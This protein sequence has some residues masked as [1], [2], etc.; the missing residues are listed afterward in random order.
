MKDLDEKLASLASVA[1]HDASPAL[2][3]RA[4]HGALA[5]L[6]RLRAHPDRPWLATAVL[7]W[8]RVFMPVTLACVVGVYLTWAFGVASA[9]Y[10]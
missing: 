5:H 3:R 7:L 8:A 9:L 4:R 10:R 6:A 2:A 1:A